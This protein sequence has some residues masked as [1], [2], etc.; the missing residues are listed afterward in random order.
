MVAVQRRRRRENK[1][2]PKTPVRKVSTLSRTDTLHKANKQKP[3]Q[4]KV[5]MWSPSDPNAPLD[6]QLSPEEPL[7]P[8]L[9]GPGWED[10]ETPLTCT[11]AQTFISAADEETTTFHFYLLS[12]RRPPVTRRRRKGVLLHWPHWHWRKKVEGEGLQGEMCLRGGKK[13]KCRGRG[14]WRGRGRGDNPKIS[15][16]EKQTKQIASKHKK[17]PAKQTHVMF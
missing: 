3:R 8:D 4:E 11:P 7:R 9:L 17:P 16:G 12:L 15:L 10:G 14:R 1:P 5:V 2:P 13:R 6:S